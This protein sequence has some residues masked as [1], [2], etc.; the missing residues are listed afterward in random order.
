MRLIRWTDKLSSVLALSGVPRY[1]GTPELFSLDI[2]IPTY[3]H[4]PKGERD[5]RYLPPR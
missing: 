1:R 4:I 3:Y 2:I 5:E